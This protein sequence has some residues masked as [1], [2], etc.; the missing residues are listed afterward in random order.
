MAKTERVMTSLVTKMG[1][2]ERV[3]TRRD[4][5]RKASIGVSGEKGMNADFT[6]VA[7]GSDLQAWSQDNRS[8]M[9]GI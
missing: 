2:T 9:G 7:G 4:T 3:M 1:L 6:Q 8:G 5:I